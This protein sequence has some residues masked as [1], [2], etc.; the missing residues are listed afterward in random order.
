MFSTEV[1]FFICAYVTHVIDISIKII[2]EP[3]ADIIKN[4]IYK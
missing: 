2:N 3:T 1:M 4:N